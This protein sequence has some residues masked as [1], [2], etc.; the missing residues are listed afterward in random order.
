M[1]TE[2]ADLSAHEFL[3]GVSA[4]A[5]LRAFVGTDEYPFLLRHGQ[6]VEGTLK[7]RCGVNYARV[8]ESGRRNPDA[9][10]LA[11][12]AKNFLI[13]ATAATP[14]SP[15]W[16]IWPG[17]EA[18]LHAYTT[19]KILYGLG[20]SAAAEIRADYL[21]TA[22]SF[23]HE[24]TA[25]F[26]A[27]GASVHPLLGLLGLQSLI[28]LG[29]AEPALLLSAGH[30]ADRLLYLT[31][32]HLSA[33]RISPLSP[34]YVLFA[35]AVLDKALPDAI[36]ESR[37][38]RLVRLTSEATKGLPA[39]SRASIIRVGDYAIGASA[40]DVLI[41]LLESDRCRKAVLSCTPLLGQTFDWLLTHR[42]HLPDGTALH[43][44]DLFHDT[45]DV[46][47]W[48]NCAISDLCHVYK[49]CVAASERKRTLVSLNAES[50]S[51]AF[52]WSD[53]KV[54]G[55]RWTTELDGR[56]LAPAR[57]RVPRGQR[58]DQNG[59]I[60][61]G[62][63]GTAKTSVGLSI[64]RALGDWPLVRI[65]PGTF[66][67][68]GSDRVFFVIDKVFRQLTT[69]AECVIL[70]DDFELLLLDRSGNSRNASWM[71]GLTT[72][73]ILP[74]FK[75]L[76]DWGRNIYIVATND[77]ESIDAS[78][79][80]ARRFDFILPVG[81]PSPN[82][83]KTLL[84]T[85]F[86]PIEWDWNSLCNELDERATIGEITQWA[87]EVLTAGM[88]MEA[89]RTFWS[90]EFSTSLQIEKKQYEAFLRA[91]QIRTFPPGIK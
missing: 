86:S 23:L 16:S 63:S 32:A 62:P 82:E 20:A 89:A 25:E 30:W 44:T 24:K 7:I 79:R 71:T 64:A 88:T 84:S 3:S 27:P 35:I 73:V 1:K 38:E 22:L 8:V 37:I 42:I 41:Y 9:Q 87:H 68:E 80:R 66:L 4:E 47:L 34:T 29:A 57:Q 15:G 17:S 59:I 52:R 85:I 33:G 10:V 11:S 26:C 69:L 67:Q 43:R 40:V 5:T 91:A 61:F 39:Y 55:F 36:D 65:S 50:S 90:T 76:H 2:H 21:S 83:R 45:N 54:G 13:D 72:D 14:P 48:F 75:S 6:S 74:W 49:S 77:I 81:P 46:D 53:V 18:Q 31:E 56:L 70:F 78:V 58:L 28:E 19:S 51:S 12:K 60:L